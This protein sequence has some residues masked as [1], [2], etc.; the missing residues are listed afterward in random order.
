MKELARFRTPDKT[1]STTSSMEIFLVLGNKSIA[2]SL[3][4]IA[5]LYITSLKINAIIN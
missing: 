1:Y 3:N 2:Y 4:G 5:E